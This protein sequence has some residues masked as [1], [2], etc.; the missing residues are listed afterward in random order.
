MK[1]HAIACPSPVVFAVALLTLWYPTAVWS[2]GTLDVKPESR[3]EIVYI[4]ASDC[5][6]CRSW[7]YTLN[8]GWKRFSQK[9]EAQYVH[10][11]TVDKGLLR[12]RIKEDDYPK[13][14][15]HLYKEAPRFGNVV[16]AWCVLVDGQPVLYGAG[17]KNWD[18]TVEPA[19]I[20]LVAQK[21][22]GMAR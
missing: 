13:G 12:F 9:P 15:R 18:T 3:I 11:I 7:R 20:D 21:L 16:P 1:K 17:E 2:T 10:L 14:Y 22:A 6:Y 4:S 19:I 5:S 8:G